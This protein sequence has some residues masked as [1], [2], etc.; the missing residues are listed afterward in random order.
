[1]QANGPAAIAG[2]RGAKSRVRV[3]N[4]LVPV[5]GDVILAIKGKSVN[6]FLELAT[7]IDRY[8][9]GDRVNVT[10]LRDNRKMDLDVTLQE[11]PRQR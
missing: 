10:V 3:G 7:E 4:Y 11:L 6:S 2:I 1:V 8:K 5:G 9:P